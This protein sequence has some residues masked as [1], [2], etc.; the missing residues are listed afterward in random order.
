MSGSHT[1]DMH[2]RYHLC[3]KC[4]TIIESRKNWIK[5][6]DHFEKNLKCPSCGNVFIVEKPL[7]RGKPLFGEPTKPEFDWT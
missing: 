6:K 1:W 2:T 7:G 3:P 4:K 5:V